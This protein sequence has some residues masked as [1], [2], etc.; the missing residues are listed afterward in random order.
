[1]DNADEVRE[2]IEGSRS[3]HVDAELTDEFID[4]LFREIKGMRE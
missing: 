4:E 2:L 1:M 3:F